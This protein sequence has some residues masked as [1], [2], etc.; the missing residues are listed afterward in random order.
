MTRFPLAASAVAAALSL[1]ACDADDLRPVPDDVLARDALDPPDDASDDELRAPDEETPPPDGE[2]P[3]ADDDTPPPD[4]DTPPPDDE[5]QTPTSSECGFAAASFT[6]PHDELSC[7]GA[8]YVRFDDVVGMFVGVVTCGSPDEVR[9]YL[10]ENV[11]GPFL[12]AADSA[13]HGQ[14]HCALVAPGFTLTNEDDITSG[15]CTTCGT[16][17]NLP[18]EGVSVWARAF[19]DEP[20]EFVA[21]TPEWH[22]QTS[23]LRCGIDVTTCGADAPAPT[24]DPEPTPVE[25]V[26]CGPGE[27]VEVGFVIPAPDM[28]MGA[29]D[30]SGAGYCFGEVA[31]FDDLSNAQDGSR[32]SYDENGSFSLVEFTYNGATGGCT[33]AHCG[34]LVYGSGASR[35]EYCTVFA[36]C[37][38]TTNL[39]RGVGYTW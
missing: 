9:V 22:F 8:R 26:P 29:S 19:L 4:D 28:Q 21:T 17:T 13:G 37:D 6:V 36:Y 30:G 27:T 38:P 23:R 5:D 16:S 35:P 24:P 12:P 10:S 25:E 39:A 20:F 18:L 15:G 3:P 32:A 7:D 34:T 14:D 2:T 1:A 11:D 31:F 33:A